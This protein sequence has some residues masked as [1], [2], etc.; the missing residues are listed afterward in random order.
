MRS[1][2]RALSAASCSSASNRRLASASIR[3]SPLLIRLAP[4]RTL[5]RIVPRPRDSMKGASSSTL[6]DQGGR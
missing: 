5:V 4:I 1:I 6:A 2:L 3:P